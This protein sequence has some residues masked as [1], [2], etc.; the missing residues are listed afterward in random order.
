MSSYAKYNV[1]D[2]AFIISNNV[3]VQELEIIKIEG[4]YCTLR[5]LDR[6]GAIRLRKSRLFPTRAEACTELNKHQKNQ[7]NGYIRPY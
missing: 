4:E 6:Y 5:E 1:G 7:S 2:R 3:K